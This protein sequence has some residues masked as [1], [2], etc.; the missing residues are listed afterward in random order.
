MKTMDIES[1]QSFSGPIAIK[2][3]ANKQYSD[4]DLLEEKLAK[5]SEISDP[6]CFYPRAHKKPHCYRIAGV[7]KDMH[8][9]KWKLNAVAECIRNKPIIDAKNIL[10]GLDKRGGKWIGELLEQLLEK[11]IRRGHNPEQIWVRTI[12]VGGSILLRKPDIK[13]RGRCGTIKK[14]KCSMRI[15]LEEKTD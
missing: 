14:P 13:G 6:V 5:A 11:A 10:A 9:S 12:T 1:N 3:T 15:V 2:V 4:M 7:K 8:Y